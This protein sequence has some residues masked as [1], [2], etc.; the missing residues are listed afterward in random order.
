VDVDAIPAPVLRRVVE[1][2]IVSHIDTGAWDQ[3]IAIEAEERRSLEDFLR[4]W[5]SGA[6]SR[7][8]A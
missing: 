5:E 1:E 2:A 7:D 3:A 6:R 4:R 8:E